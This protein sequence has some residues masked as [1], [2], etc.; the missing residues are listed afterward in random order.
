MKTKPYT[1]CNFLRFSNGC[2][3]CIFD[4]R[5]DQIDYCTQHGCPIRDKSS[6]EFRV[7]DL[8]WVIWE[9]VESDPDYTGILSPPTSNIEWAIANEGEVHTNAKCNFRVRPTAKTSFSCV[10]ECNLVSACTYISCPIKV[11]DQTS[12]KT[13]VENLFHEAV[14]HPSHYCSHPS[15]IECIQVTQHFNFNRGNAIKYIWRAGQ[16]GNAI[17]DLKKARKYIDFELERIKN[18]S[19]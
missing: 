13:L 1:E 15:G 12:E 3:V 16:K 11:D 10:H 7:M 4:A 2:G 14:D 19:I 6:D 9:E 18:E 5:G 8:Q 17:K